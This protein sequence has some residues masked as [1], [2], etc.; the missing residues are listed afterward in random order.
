MPSPNA[1][2][3]SA[4]NNEMELIRKMRAERSNKVSSTELLPRKFRVEKSDGVAN[5]P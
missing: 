4:R 1:N 3:V 2:W 5:G